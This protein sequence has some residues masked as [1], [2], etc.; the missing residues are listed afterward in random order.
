MKSD[1]LQMVIGRVSVH[2]YTRA[3]LTNTETRRDWYLDTSRVSVKSL[4][5]RSLL[6]RSRLKSHRVRL[7]C[8]TQ[9]LSQLPIATVDRCVPR[10]SA[11]R[12]QKYQSLYATSQAIMNRH[13]VILAAT[14]LEHSVWIDTR[15]SSMTP[16]KFR[17]LDNASLQQCVNDQAAWS[18]KNNNSETA[19]MQ[20]SH[21]G[22]S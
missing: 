5:L 20:A 14:R 9:L 1:T 16:G 11:Y 12:Y 10:P 19:I 18:K 7:V 2:S 15:K 17:T 3:R 13:R 22:C 21:L 4:F 8:V 6:E